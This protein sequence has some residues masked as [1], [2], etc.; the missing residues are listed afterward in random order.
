MKD[1]IIK[2]ISA[3]LERLSLEQLKQV[4]SFVRGMVRRNYKG[5]GNAGNHSPAFF[6]SSSHAAKAWSR[7]FHHS[8]VILIN[9]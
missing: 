3:Y 8:G 6:F 7:T 9:T 1:T 2:M 5:K 4:Y